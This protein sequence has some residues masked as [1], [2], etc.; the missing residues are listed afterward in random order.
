MYERLF[1]YTDNKDDII[2]LMIDAKSK[3]TK[4]FCEVIISRK[5]ISTDKNFYELLDMFKNWNKWYHFRFIWDTYP[6][7]HLEIWLSDMCE[8][9]GND[10]Y[11]LS[12]ELN[13]KY[14]T[15]FIKK[16]KLKRIVN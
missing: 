8:N 2:N 7:D 1:Y 14:F 13:I 11:V 5:R 9:N 16:Y 12:L 3:A 4:V 10:E 15:Y 6:K